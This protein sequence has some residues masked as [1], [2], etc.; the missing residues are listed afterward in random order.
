MPLFI[1][2]EA[3][4]TPC[5]RECGTNCAKCIC[6]CIFITPCKTSRTLFNSFIFQ[7]FISFNAPP[8]G[9]WSCGLINEHVDS[10]LT[11][12]IRVFDFLNG[13]GCTL[14]S[15]WALD[16]PNQ[17]LFKPKLVQIKP[18]YGSISLDNKNHSSFPL[19]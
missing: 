19:A 5:T 6:T 3:Q 13:E 9:F 7:V 17:G 2:G 18:I 10:L 15:T 12:L 8:L 1:K 11:S 16:S 4:N 14:T